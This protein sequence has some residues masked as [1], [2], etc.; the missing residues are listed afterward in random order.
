MLTL[1]TMTG[2][3]AGTDDYKPEDQSTTN[4]N[5][6]SK[7]NT[8]K[9]NVTINIPTEA[10]DDSFAPMDISGGILLRTIQRRDDPASENG[11]VATG[12][13]S[14][15]ATFTSFSTRS[16]AKLDSYTAMV[17]RI[18]R[19]C[20]SLNKHQPTGYHGTFYAEDQ[21]S[22]DDSKLDGMLLYFYILGC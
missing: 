7:E 6:T 4:R 20:G 5:Q 11:G 12:T 18:S 17:E 2:K 14:P 22:E 19:G 15:G 21:Y 13:S 10:I 9:T 16:S 8:P 3:S 1:Q